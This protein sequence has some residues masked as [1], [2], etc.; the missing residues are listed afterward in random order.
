MPSLFE[1]LIACA[2]KKKCLKQLFSREKN[3]R[4]WFKLSQQ[5]TNVYLKVLYIPQIAN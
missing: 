3:L 4:I 2:W 1:D 5:G